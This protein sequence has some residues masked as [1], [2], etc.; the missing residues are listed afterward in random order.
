MCFDLP[1]QTVPPTP[2]H[3]PPR[4]ASLA[5]LASLVPRNA[6]AG[7]QQECIVSVSKKSALRLPSSGPTRVKMVLRQFDCAFLLFGA[8]IRA[9]ECPTKPVSA[10][11]F[12][13][14]FSHLHAYSQGALGI[15]H[16]RRG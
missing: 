6:S 5:V 1:L 3:R 14:E 15:A 13:C 8:A 7:C 4:E 11:S 12:W 2:P 16:L 10:E 9:A